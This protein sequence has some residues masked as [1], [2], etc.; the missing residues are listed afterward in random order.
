MS[1]GTGINLELKGKIALFT[2]SSSDLDMEIEKYLA[3]TGATMA[4]HYHSEKLQAEQ[5]T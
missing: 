1:Y 4:I 5:L 3:R 2:G